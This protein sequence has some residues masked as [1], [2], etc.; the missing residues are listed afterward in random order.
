[1]VVTC[2]QTLPTK[3]TSSIYVFYNRK[4]KNYFNNFIEKLCTYPCNLP[5]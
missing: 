4:C 2:K 5:H 3:F 1:M